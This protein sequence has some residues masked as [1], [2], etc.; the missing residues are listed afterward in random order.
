MKLFQ[1]FTFLFAFLASTTAIF[2]QELATKTMYNMM[3]LS[4]NPAY[5]GDFEG[6]FRIG[7]MYKDYQS[8]T[9]Q[10]P[11]FFVDVPIIMIRKRDWISAG[12]SFDADNA[13]TNDFNTTRSLISASYHLSLDKKG[14]NYLVAGYQFGSD[15][16]RL[17]SLQ[18]NGVFGE[19]QD[20]SITN[21]D[22]DNATSSRINNIGLMYRSEIDKNTDFTI[23]AAFNYIFRQDGTISNVSQGV[24]KRPSS[25]VVHG[26]VN[27]QLN[28]KL[29]IHPSF[30]VRAKGFEGTDAMVQA[31]VGY[32]FSEEKQLTLRGGLGYDLDQGPALLLGA[33]Y[34]DWR[35][36][37]SYEF[38][39]Y[40][41]AD[42]LENIGG[43]E[44][45]ASRI[46]KIYK[47]PV[48]DPAICCP[49]L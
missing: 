17:K 33:D 3:P 45:S 7:G 37:L 15:N 10:T 32:L 27:R 16:T 34:G 23:G 44:I 30:I 19:A 4:V 38:P 48:V 21:I 29:S 47:K 9:F 8:S 1:Q 12:I 42:A 28:D 24:F 36:G 46:I 18:T 43:F 35:F 26:L 11:S 20:P 25:I 5:T 41:I 2:A 14:K 6:S 22:P 49:D 13:G 31:M 39:L 40:G